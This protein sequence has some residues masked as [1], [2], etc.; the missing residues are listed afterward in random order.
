MLHSAGFLGF[1]RWRFGF[2]S[3]M[4]QPAFLSLPLQYL[5]PD[6]SSVHVCFLAGCWRLQVVPHVVWMPARTGDWKMYAFKGPGM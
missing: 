6:S 4:C 3:H 1:C 5:N 2:V